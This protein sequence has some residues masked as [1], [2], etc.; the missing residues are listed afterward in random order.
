MKKLLESI[1]RRLICQPGY[2]LLTAS[3]ERLSAGPAERFRFAWFSLMV[4]SLLCGV[5]LVNV[6]GLTWMLFGDFGVVIVPGLATAAVFL[7][8]PFRRTSAALT[9]LLGG[10]DA[11][12]RSIVAALLVVAL[13]LGFVRMDSSVVYSEP[14]LPGWIAWARPHHPLYRVL[15]LMPLWGGWSMLIVGQFSRPGERTEPAVRS[16]VKGCGP[17]AAAG[18]MGVVLAA[19]ILYFSFLPWTQLSISGAAIVAA[20]AGGLVLTRLAG[21]IRRT[22]L[23]ATNVLTQ[24]AFLFAYLAVA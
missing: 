5:L 4:L 16:F 9:E 1:C 3:D 22:S 2:M 10:R 19:T 12:S 15:L 21:G 17:A 7:L 20:I 24:L 14:S 8:W 11:T 23:L 13:V 18:C 6:W